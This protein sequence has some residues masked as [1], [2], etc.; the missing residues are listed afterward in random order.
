MVSPN[1]MENYQGDEEE[2]PKHARFVAVQIMF[3]IKTAV[4]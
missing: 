1:M 3:L 4:N 2:C